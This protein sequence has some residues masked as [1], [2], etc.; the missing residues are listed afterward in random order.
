MLVVVEG[1]CGGLHLHRLSEGLQPGEGGLGRARPGLRVRGLLAQVVVAERLSGARV[2]EASSAGV[3][4]VGHQAG[5]LRALHAG[6]GQLVLVVLGEG[7]AERKI[8]KIR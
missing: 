6:G 7:T 8:G 1:V 2:L 4:V 3:V 5:Q